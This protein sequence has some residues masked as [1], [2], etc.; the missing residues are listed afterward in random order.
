MN[1]KRILTAAKVLS[2]LLTPYYLPIFGLIVLFLFSYLS[3]L[4]TGYKWQVGLLVYIFTVLAPTLLIRLYRNAQGWTHVELLQREHRIVPY[5]I[6]IVLYFACYYLLRRLHTPHVIGSIVIAALLI[7][8]VCALINV[9]WK[10]STHT[11][12]IGAVGGGL[13]AFAFRLHFD[14]TAWLA[15]VFLFG[16]LVGSSRMILKQHSLAQ[17]VA[18]F[19]I[20]VACSFF[21]LFF[22]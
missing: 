14:P 17:V 5:V 6:T 10:V 21:V 3:L 18:G 22:F 20:G 4:P 11:A 8:V 1:D 19:F 9:W 2:M 12:A 15:L 7:Q 13:T 16:G